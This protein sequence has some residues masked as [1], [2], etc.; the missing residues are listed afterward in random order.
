MKISELLASA[1]KETG[2]NFNGLLRKTARIK[3]GMGSDL[4]DVLG[5]D[6]VLRSKDGDCYSYYSA[7]APLMG[8]TMAQ[9]VMC[10]LGIVA[11]DDYKIGIKEAIQIFHTQNGGDKF[12][13]ICLSWPLVHPAAIEPH[14]HFRTNLGNDVVIGANS[15]QINWAEA[16]SLTK[17]MAK[18]H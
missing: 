18:Q 14:W 4:S 15:G 5:W 10:P 2:V 13:Q 6:I 1:K 3:H 17:Q 12:T 9:P 16:R 11:F 7:Q 8:T